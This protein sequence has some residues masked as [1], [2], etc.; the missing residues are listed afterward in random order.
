[1]ALLRERGKFKSPGS[2]ECRNANIFLAGASAAPIRNPKVQRAAIA[3]A[4]RWTK[5]EPIESHKIN[6]KGDY[7]TLGETGVQYA[8]IHNPRTGE[9]LKKPVRAS[10]LLPSSVIRELSAVA[11]ARA[12]GMRAE[13]SPKAAR[14]VGHE[15]GGHWTREVTGVTMRDKARLEKTWERDPA[16]L[17]RDLGVVFGE[18]AAMGILK[19]YPTTRIAEILDTVHEERMADEAAIAG[20]IRRGIKRSGARVLRNPQQYMRVVEEGTK[21][22]LKGRPKPYQR[23]VL[24]DIAIMRASVMGAQFRPPKGPTA[25]ERWANT[26][27]QFS[28]ETV[29]GFGSIGQHPMG[30]LIRSGGPAR[31]VNE[32]M[33]RAA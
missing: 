20:E 22:V 2:R 21:E 27:E 32:G 10:I 13:L 5:V 12:A 1:M 31:V 3:S 29:A 23:A 11:K 7:I 25:M 8:I 16:Q 17:R 18:K 15:M 19:S 33:R 9:V 26:L 30:E 14:L 28:R 4:L 24:A 6:P